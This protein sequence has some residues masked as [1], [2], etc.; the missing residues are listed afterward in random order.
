MTMKRPVIFLILL[1]FSNR[2]LGQARIKVEF[3]V[4][5]PDS[6][7]KGANVFIAGSFNNWDPGNVNWALVRPAAPNSYDRIF[8]FDPGN[9][10]YKI[11]RGS[12]PAV[13]CTAKGTEAENRTLHV[14]HDTTIVIRV[15]GWKD[16]LPAAVTAQK[17]TASKNVHLLSAAFNMPQLGKQR[18]IWIYLPPGYTASK[19]RYP[20]IYMHDG[21]NLFDAY[22]A[23][24][25]EWGMDEFLD[26]LKKAQRQVI[27]IGID[28]GG[29]DRIAEYSPYDSEYAKG[30]GDAYA[31]FL[32]ETLKP[33]IDKHY[34]TLPDAKHTTI[35]GSSM[36]G[37]I[38]MYAALKYP[39]VFGNAGIFSPAFWI[40]PKIYDLAQ[41]NALKN[42]RYY[43]ICGD[44][45]SDKEVNDMNKMVSILSQKGLPAKNIPSTVI[46][47]AKHNE[48]QWRGDLP[49]F[50]SWLVAGF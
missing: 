37:L 3:V 18:R 32:A 31:R 17:H 10:E 11:T 5:T 46:K 15:A 20:V 35:A 36:G 8:F 40:N 30:I 23:G 42:S 25:G 41:N 29:N 12:W 33:Y 9:Y 50:Y 48:Q 34:R 26:S 6:S 44:Q 13:E 4:T 21:Q 38:S 39:K 47:G 24:F 22:T 7:P 1:L 27:I 16:K 19:K 28:H 2:L 45:E 43:F 49:G 14:L